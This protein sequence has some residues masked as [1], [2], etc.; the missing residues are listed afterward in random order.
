MTIHSRH[1]PTTLRAAEAD[2]DAFIHVSDLFAIL[3]T[4]F[5]HLCTD[6]AY[7][8]VK[9]G[10]AKHEIS[11]HLAELCAIQHEPEVFRFDMLAAGFQTVV[12]RHLQAGS[13]ALCA[14]FN[15]ALHILVHCGGMGHNGFPRMV[16]QHNGPDG[17]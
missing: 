8:L 1:L 16:E 17:A 10:T 13:V 9:G 11:R 3:R 7:A 6:F 5:A 15:T 12:H 4:C 2:L 14:R